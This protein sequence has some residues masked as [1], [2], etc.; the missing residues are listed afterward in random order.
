[1]TFR[2]QTVRIAILQ[3]T[4]VGTQY[5]N[6]QLKEDMGRDELVIKGKLTRHEA[7]EESDEWAKVRRQSLMQGRLYMRS[8]ALIGWG[9]RSR[10]EMP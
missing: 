3:V 4:Q 10:N 5:L 9:G 6:D 1:M 2:L 8:S 7:D